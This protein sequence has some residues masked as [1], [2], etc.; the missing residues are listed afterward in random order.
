MVN[1]VVEKIRRNMCITYISGCEIEILVVVLE[2]L[3]IVVFLGT[4]D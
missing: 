4:H 3:N 2:V 1:V